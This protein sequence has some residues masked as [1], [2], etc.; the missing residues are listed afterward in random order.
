V[1]LESWYNNYGEEDFMNMAKNTASRTAASATKTVSAIGNKTSK[2]T[3]K[4]KKKT[5]KKKP[6]TKKQAI[7]V[8]RR[9]ATR[10][11]DQLVNVLKKDLEDTKATLK[12]VKAAA[13]NE[14]ALMRDL[15]DAAL[16]RE[17]ELMKISEKKAKKMFVAG[18]QWEKKQVKK[19]KR[20]AE[21]TRAR[22]KK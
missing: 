13:K 22:I 7:A 9:A 15:L 16:K 10:T 17:K 6:L 21:R 14:I 3:S 1:G 4:A 20:A 5:T 8:K 12:V 19:L 11:R 2:K 18:E